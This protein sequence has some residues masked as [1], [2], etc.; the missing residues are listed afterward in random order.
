MDLSS[1]EINKTAPEKIWDFQTGECSGVAESSFIRSQTVS[2]DDSACFYVCWFLSFVFCLFPCNEGGFPTV[3]LV[4][5][6]PFHLKP[7]S[8]LPI[9]Q[10]LHL[11]SNAF[12]CS[13]P[14]KETSPLLLYVFLS[15]TDETI[16]VSCK[17]GK[18]FNFLLTI[19]IHAACFFRS[20]ILVDDLKW[21]DCMLQIPGCNHLAILH[22]ACKVARF[23]YWRFSAARSHLSIHRMGLPLLLAK[24][25]F[26]I[27]N[28]EC[29]IISKFSMLPNLPDPIIS[30]SPRW[31]SRTSFWGQ[32]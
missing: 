12:L 7:V 9:W 6:L 5:Y 21:T 25:H 29:Q 17:C 8:S 13:P 4:C 23:A 16:L 30:R 14:H 26:F 2:T 24:Y 27:W 1:T 18:W 19:V 22:L 28:E 15:D 20:G 10:S 3:I 31:K 11:L 32:W